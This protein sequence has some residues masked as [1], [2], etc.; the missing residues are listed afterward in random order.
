M[1]EKEVYQTPSEQTQLIIDI[2]PQN[3]TKLHVTAVKVLHVLSREIV[4]L[5][6]SRPALCSRARLHLQLFAHTSL[7]KNNTH[8]RTHLQMWRKADTQTPTGECDRAL[9]V[10]AGKHIKDKNESGMPAVALEASGGEK[11]ST[12]RSAARWEHP[13]RVTDCWWSFPKGFYCGEVGF[14]AFS[15][16]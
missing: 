11:Q 1:P 6:D 5:V 4:Q 12:A 14:R 13:C 3:A 7:N 15:G 10:W 9:S 2:R 8:T 16:A